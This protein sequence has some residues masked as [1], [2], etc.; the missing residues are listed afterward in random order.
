MKT[1]QDY[2]KTFL[3]LIL[4]LLILAACG[5]K[6]EENPRAQIAGESSKSWKI[7]REIT[8]SGQ[9]DKMTGDEKDQ[10]M[11][12]YAN[13]TFKIEADNQF[14][15]GRWNY[16]AGAKTMELVFDDRQDTKEVFQ[17]LELDDNTIKLQAGD[18]STMELK[19]D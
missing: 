13:G 10:R 11:E 6:N 19:K 7:K 15:G 14:E 8:A 1:Y 9:K 16:N 18:G 4:P 17:V 5:N 3:T 12:F 2:L